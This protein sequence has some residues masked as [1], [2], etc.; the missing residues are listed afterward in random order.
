MA[1]SA[2]SSTE[3]TASPTV[4]TATDVTKTYTRGSRPGAIGRALGRS[5]PPTVRAVDSVSLA[6]TEGE[7]VGLAGPSGSGKSTLL[8][9]LAGLERPTAGT[10]SFQ[11]TDLATLS[12]RE[13]TRHRLDHVGIVF[14]HFHLLD[15]L[16]AQANVALPLVE[17][18]VPKRERR[19]RATTLLERVDLG[20]RLTHRPGELSGG[21]QQRVAIARA[22]ATDPALV[23]ADEPTGEL[24][25]A[26]GRT[27]LRE[28]ERVA[29]NRTVVLAS[30]DRAT[31]ECCDR[32]LWLRDGAI[33]DR[34]QGPTP[35]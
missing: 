27:V 35:E 19:R 23:I 24:D 17:R 9:L 22:L 31:L 26:A 4:V 28:F 33:V 25:T 21:E 10:V 30:H 34:P 32:L 7:L 11:G 29:E 8:H 15:A 13:R 16:S 3:T 1:G 6:I 20:D 18:G 5:E 2:A 14:Q 12:R